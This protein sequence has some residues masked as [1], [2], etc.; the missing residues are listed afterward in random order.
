M[1]W[2]RGFGVEM[3]CSS[4]SKSVLERGP[5]REHVCA[6]QK[7]NEIADVEVSGAARCVPGEVSRTKMSKNFSPNLVEKNPV[8]M[9]K[10]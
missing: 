2:S 9:E 10:I 1:H 5:G 8:K 3:P 7:A 6:P 4:V